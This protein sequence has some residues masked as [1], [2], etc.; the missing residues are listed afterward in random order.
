MK[1]VLFLLPSLVV[2]TCT[3]ASVGNASSV[4]C[5]VSESLTNTT[6]KVN[7]TEEEREQVLIEG[8]CFLGC[9]LERYGEQVHTLLHI[10]QL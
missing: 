1:S 8:R 9:A 2:I 6:F 10:L 3:L 5:R 7:L 4:E